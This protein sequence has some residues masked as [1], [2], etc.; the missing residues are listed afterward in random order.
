MKSRK[1]AKQVLTAEQQRKLDHYD[2]IMAN[3]AEIR[4]ESEAS[5]AI[6]RAQARGIHLSER[7]KRHLI[8]GLEK[9]NMKF[10]AIQRLAREIEDGD[11]ELN[12]AAGQGVEA[13]SIF[14]ALESDALNRMLGEGGVGHFSEVLDEL[15]QPIRRR[16]P[17][18]TKPA[19][20][21]SGVLSELLVPSPGQAG[22]KPSME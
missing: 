16:A 10:A 21:S 11:R 2:R 13:L 22:E 3:V 8:H 1:R 12:F 4:A 7:D 9:L 15:K 6:R 17:E 18:K 20:P 19:A 5:K 14:G